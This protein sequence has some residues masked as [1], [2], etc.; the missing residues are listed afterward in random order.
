MEQF[1]KEKPWEAWKWNKE[2]GKFD[3]ALEKH[4]KDNSGDVERLKRASKMVADARERNKKAIEEMTRLEIELAEASEEQKSATLQYDTN[5]KVLD[6]TMREQQRAVAKSV[7]AEKKHAEQEKK[8]EAAEKKRK[9]EEEQR[10][11]EQEQDKANRRKIRDLERATAKRLSEMLP[12]IEKMKKAAEDWSEKAKD[13]SGK[14]FGQW[15]GDER[16]KGRE[17][18]RQ[19]NA[20]LKNITNAQDRRR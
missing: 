4:D 16:R 2:V 7:E 5:M 3:V 12:E 10:K 17:E 19:V 13:A 14:T 18:E 11:L 9:Q 1:A 20:K 15:Q 8:R 6:E